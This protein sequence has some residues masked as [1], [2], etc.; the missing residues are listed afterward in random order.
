MYP[1]P[2]PTLPHPQA[3]S[4][5]SRV[6]TAWPPVPGQPLTAI[7]VPCSPGAARGSQGTSLSRLGLP[8]EP[9]P[10]PPGPGSAW[11]AGWALPRC[12]GDC[13]WAPEGS[14]PCC[15]LSHHP[16]VCPQMSWGCR[17]LPARSGLLSPPVFH[18]LSHHP[19]PRPLIPH[20]QPCV[21]PATCHLPVP[22]PRAARAARPAE[23]L[24]PGPRSKNKYCCQKH[25]P[26]P[27]SPR[28][29]GESTAGRR[30][31]SVPAAAALRLAQRSPRWAGSGQ[32][33]AGL[34]PGS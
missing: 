29:S 19:L 1:P 33:A 26:Q 11:A 17:M 34:R 8:E 13:L 16:S 4:T 3:S 15:C 7:A 9:T 12:F 23:T 27:R 22:Q 18:R 31:G 28:P 32:R 30:G 24:P 14:S 6:P 2:H 10:V 25:P 5:H 21:S 20:S